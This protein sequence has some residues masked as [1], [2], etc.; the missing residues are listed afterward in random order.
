MVCDGRRPLRFA[1]NP[2]G[3]VGGT[4]G[5]HDRRGSPLKCPGGAQV[6]SF[7]CMDGVGWVR[8]G[9]QGTSPRRRREGSL[10]GSLKE[11]RF[12]S[13]SPGERSRENNVLS[14]G[15]KSPL[16][17][18]K[19]THQPTPALQRHSLEILW[20]GARTPPRQPKPPQHTART[21]RTP[22]A[23]QPPHA[24]PHV[25]TAPTP[26]RQRSRHTTRT[27]SKTRTHAHMCAPGSFR[28]CESTV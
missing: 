13:D 24:A 3:G 18:L 15:K 16:L 17:Y 9:A 19:P 12:A 6:L 28:D 4:S 23:P 21:S 1:R 22:H 25:Y 10:K 5:A 14:Q 2:T 8:P 27:H 20:R 26:H 7:G 11:N